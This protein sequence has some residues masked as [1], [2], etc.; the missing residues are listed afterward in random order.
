MRQAGRVEISCPAIQGNVGEIDVC[1]YGREFYRAQPRWQELDGCV[2]K[3][4]IPSLT[5][6]HVSFPK[7]LGD[8]QY[9]QKHFRV[10]GHRG[11]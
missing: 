8:I 2:I 7:Y 11:G 4:S 6:H 9:D 10:L 3:N 1:F 5:I